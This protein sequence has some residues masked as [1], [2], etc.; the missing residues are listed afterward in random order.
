MKF[1]LK[2]KFCQRLLGHEE[3]KSLQIERKCVY[4]E[5]IFVPDILGSDSLWVGV[6][7]VGLCT[8]GQ[9]LA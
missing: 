5:G 1:P 4:L 3:T 6:Q 7:Q 2:S 8:V 9:P